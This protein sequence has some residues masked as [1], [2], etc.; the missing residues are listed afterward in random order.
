MVKIVF[1]LSLS[2][3][4]IPSRKYLGIILGIPESVNFIQIS[5]EL[6]LKRFGS[7]ATNFIT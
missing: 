4:L 5:K 3:H 7:F 1:I 2:E 6:K